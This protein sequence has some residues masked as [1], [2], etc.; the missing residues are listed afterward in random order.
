MAGSIMILIWAFNPLCSQASFR[1]A[2]L[3]PRTGTSFS[4]FTYYNATLDMQLALSAFSSGSTRSL[5]KIRASYST[6]VYDYVSSTQY[7]DLMN[8]RTMAVLATLVEGSSAGI[9][10]ATDTWGNVRL[11]GLED[12]SGYDASDPQQRL[13]IPWDK[14]VL[15]CTSLLGDRF[16]GIHRSLIGNTSFM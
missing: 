5:P 1:G 10:A 15:N 14:K 12:L 9:Q 7:V 8:E 6:A 16:D 4:Q 11:P 3:R 2:Y 13:D